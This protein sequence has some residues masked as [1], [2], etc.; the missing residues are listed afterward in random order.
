MLILN[1]LDRVLDGKLELDCPSMTWSQTGESLSGAGYI[2]QSIGGGFE[3]ALFSTTPGDPAD[4]FSREFAAARS[5]PAGT[6][7]PRDAGGELLAT[8]VTGQKWTAVGLRPERMVSQHQTVK[9]SARELRTI[10]QAPSGATC[11]V[12]VRIAGRVRFPSNVPSN[13]TTSL[14]GRVVAMSVG[15]GAAD[16][17]L[18]GANLRARE[19]TGGTSFLLDSAAPLRPGA[20]FRLLD[21]V[22]FLENSPVPWCS[23]SRWEGGDA[24]F[25]LR[26]DR[27]EP[28]P[29]FALPPLPE[30]EAN[31]YWRLVSS[32]V[33]RPEEMD[34]S[35]RLWID[36]TTTAAAWP[37]ESRGLITTIAIEAMSDLLL[38]GFAPELAGY[39]LADEERARRVI[40]EAEMPDRLARRLLGLL[41]GRG[42]SATDRLFEL[43]RLGVASREEVEAWKGL[44]H[45]IA[46]GTLPAMGQDLV[47]GVHRVR[48][49][50]SR[51]VFTAVGYEGPYRDHGTAG[52]P[53]RQHSCAAFKARGA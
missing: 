47:D 22:R 50:F 43:S 26:G 32:L 46:H 13:V 19:V 12:E 37:L 10:E 23:L 3:F 27:Y 53:V 5:V 29:R 39:S 40:E 6:L 14:G 2:R 35:L 20:E 30:D 1:G 21:A 36:V 15:P 33:D 51:L 11:L 8:D 4:W 31:S 24:T 17:Q 7:L 25:R 18:D 16:A 41:Q 44:R 49:L 34:S 52:W 38:P 9:G 48:T 28:R 42:A 45:P